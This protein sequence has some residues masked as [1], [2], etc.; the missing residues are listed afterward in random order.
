MQKFVFPARLI[1]LI[2]AVSVV[3]GSGL[4]P[5]IYWHVSPVGASSTALFA[6]AF[7]SPN[8]SAPP[9][10]FLCPSGAASCASSG[11][12]LP[13]LLGWEGSV[14]FTYPP[15]C[16]SASSAGACAFQFCSGADPSACTTV[17]DPNAPDV[18]WAVA[19]P[20][21]PGT[22]FVPGP[23]GD[24]SVLVNDGAGALVSGGA[25]GGGSLL[26]LFGRALAFAGGGALECIPATGRTP[27]A[28]S[29]LRLSAQAPPLPALVATCYELTFNLSAAPAQGGL[30]PGVGAY[31]DATLT[32]PFGSFALPLV[33]AAT[34]PPSSGGTG[35]VTIDVDGDAGG[36]VSAAL[37]L[38][39][40]AGPGGAIVVL[41][42]HA[43]ALSQPLSMPNGTALVGAGAAASVLVFSFPPEGQVPGSAAISGAGSSDWGLFD[44]GVLIL[45]APAGTAAVHMAPGTANMTA[46]RVNV[47][48]A[49]T[50]VS[51][52]FF[53]EGAGWE[54]AS[55]F[56]LQGGVCLWP[57]SNDD[58]D[59]PI[60]V[61]FRLHGAS[62]GFF[63]G[64]TLL[65]QCSAFDM[66][67]SSRVVFEDN[68]LTCTQA[69]VIPH[70]NSI[71]SYDQL[72]IPF[73]QGF[74]YSH[75]VQSRPPNNNRTNW[76][77]HESLTTDG[78]GGWGAG[79]IGA[80]DGAT[81]NVPVGLNA[82]T[83]AA[84][85]TALIVAG[86]GA[87]QWRGVLARPNATAVQIS[88][89]FDEHV[90]ANASVVAIIATVGSKI[91]GGN[92]FTWG[93]VVQEFG[94]TI[95]GVFA[96]NHFD[97]QNNAMADAGDVDGSL[98][99][100]GLCYG[101]E[102]EPM[103]YVEYVDNVMSDSNGI[104]LHDVS[105]NSECNASYPG[106]YIRWAVVRGNSIG[107]IAPSN[108][109]I[110][111]SINATNPAT[112]DLLVEGNTFE[113]PPGGFLP[114]GNGLNIY[115]AHSVVQ[116]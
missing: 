48:M 42:A 104:A 32:T 10:A 102:P 31:P 98:T 54:V 18:W 74:S 4:S 92:N 70:G 2:A 41:G 25:G 99:G 22:V 96:D 113:C 30:A 46:L 20:P 49:Q 15:A 81:V 88:A 103:F 69:G 79:V 38:A 108:P 44:L 58:T 8:A 52:A 40:A 73:S 17:P 16:A 64:N 57:P 7:A 105:P 50:N 89:P 51:N 94:S 109:G 116:Q 75:N 27:S 111:G 77:F 80:I 67:V 43:Y 90:V 66:D 56:I 19:H 72:S 115:A 53:I 26:R 78:P 82:D 85:A 114:G 47:T 110:C 3:A 100:F 60:S 68:N 86:P 24:G 61:T 11:A 76:G 36:N 45:S 21:L 39:A 112:S 13:L 5:A 9:T 29:T 6:G 59:F 95:T 33:V 97:H 62:D 101:N 63:R 71:S 14:A 28:S 83:H 93:S 107:G 106:P 37:A 87:G 84:G 12:A 55:S 65:W 34:T 1:S 35:P 91:I 23:T